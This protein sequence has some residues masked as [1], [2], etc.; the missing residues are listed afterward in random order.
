MRA[1]WMVLITGILVFGVAGAAFAHV[2]VSP[3]EVPAGGTQEFTVEAVGEKEVPATEVRLE[4]PEGFRVTGVPETPGWQGG[5]EGGSIIWSG[6]EINPDEA[7][8]FVFEAEAPAEP[9]ATTWNGFVTYEDGSVIEWNGPPD[10]EKPATVVEVLSSGSASGAPEETPGQDDDHA[11]E[12][13]SE[14]L[15]ESGGIHPGLLVAVL[16][17][18]ALSMGVAARA[19][20]RRG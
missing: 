15:P 17:G 18:L 4:V 10:S 3:T 2:E 7:E 12:A 8:E 6:G 19:G 1:A 5:Q 11:A 20:L 14:S 16:G 13:A 9:G